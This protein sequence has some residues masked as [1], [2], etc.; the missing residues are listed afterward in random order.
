MLKKFNI[1]KKSVFKQTNLELKNYILKYFEQQESKNFLYFEGELITFLQQINS[2]LLIPKL[3]DE[4]L[5]K[6]INYKFYKLDRENY[7]IFENI[8]NFNDFIDIKRDIKRCN[9]SGRSINFK[10]TI[11]GI[12]N[13]QYQKDGIL[14]GEPYYPNQGFNYN[15]DIQNI[16]KLKILTTNNILNKKI[17]LIVKFIL[18]NGELIKKH[19][20]LMKL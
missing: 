6:Q 18:S 16:K 10:N 2:N 5:E 19:I 13:L 8:E 9:L 11:K 4:D 12:C 20:F 3:F 14:R 7:S 1:D 15:Y 17:S